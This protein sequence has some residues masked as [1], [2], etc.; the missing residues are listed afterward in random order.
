[1]YEDQ[2]YPVQRFYIITTRIPFYTDVLTMGNSNRN[3]QDRIYF[4]ITQFKYLSTENAFFRII[5]TIFLMQW[6]WIILRQ[7]FIFA[8]HISLGISL[9]GEPRLDCSTW[10]WF[11]EVLINISS[12]CTNNCNK[13]RIVYMFHHSQD[14]QMIATVYIPSLAASV[15][16]RS[17][18]IL[19][20]T[21]HLLFQ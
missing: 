11:F 10:S 2:C 17:R 15:P 6:I 21:S 12:H 14:I 9:L 13:T 3:M 7:K 18:L 8:F 20:S 16:F 4:V 5:W 1:M 19:Q